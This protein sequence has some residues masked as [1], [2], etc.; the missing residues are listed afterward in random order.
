LDGVDVGQ[1]ADVES[2]VA[3][4]LVTLHSIRADAFGMGFDFP[5]LRDPSFARAAETIRDLNNAGLLWHMDESPDSIVTSIGGARLFTRQQCETLERV[6]DSLWAVNWGETFEDIH[7][8]CLH[9]QGHWP[10]LGAESGD[11]DSFLA[12]H[13]ARRGFPLD[14]LDAARVD[15]GAFL[16][17]AFSGR[18]GE[19]SPFDAAYVADETL[20]DCMGGNLNLPGFTYHAAGGDCRALRAVRNGIEWLIC[21]SGDGGQ[22][23][24]AGAAGTLSAFDVESGN[25]RGEWHLPPGGVTPGVVQYLMARHGSR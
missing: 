22:I 3:A 20:A 18:R 12:A 13:C 2:S 17:H 15:M 19:I 8:Y 5:I 6:R 24:V 9:A 14:G 21:T 7:G 11:L 4:A 23:P 1:F 16:A 25:E 10:L